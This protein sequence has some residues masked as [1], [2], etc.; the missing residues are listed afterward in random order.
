[1][2]DTKRFRQFASLA[3]GE[4]K[5]STQRYVI[6]C[7]NDTHVLSYLGLANSTPLHVRQFSD[8]QHIGTDSVRIDRFS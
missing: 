7:L 8:S 6:F 1:M 3:H 2:S 4:K 5:V